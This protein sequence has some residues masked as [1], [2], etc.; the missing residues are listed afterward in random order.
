MFFA[1]VIGRKE[2]PARKD[3]EDGVFE[4]L[5]VFVPAIGG[6]GFFGFEED[7]DREVCGVSA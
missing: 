6:I 5:I 4:S 1:E 3:R 2:S 7:K